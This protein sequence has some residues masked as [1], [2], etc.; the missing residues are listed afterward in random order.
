MLPSLRRET[1]EAGLRIPEHLKADVAP[2]PLGCGLQMQ[3]LIESNSSP[4]VEGYLK[5]YQ[6]GPR[7]SVRKCSPGQHRPL[8][9]TDR[10]KE[11]AS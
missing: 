10:N 9:L 6:S 5:S 4:I 11:P 7:K 2:S 8:R 1:R 3:A